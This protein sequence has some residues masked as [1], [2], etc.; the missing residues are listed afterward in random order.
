MSADYIRDGA[1]IYRRSFAIIR[2]E[3]ELARFTPAEERVAVR[4]IHA[5]GMVEVAAGIAF[6]PGAAE[7]GIA[8]LAAGRSGAVRAS[9]VADG[10]TRARLTAANDVLCTLRD[11]RVPASRPRSVPPARPRRWSCGPTRSAARSWRSAT[12]PPLC[13]V[14]SS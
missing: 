5:C 11:S 6:A 1:E 13:S 12:R 7:A 3:A 2:A 10:V 9:M 14:C 8:A 4:V